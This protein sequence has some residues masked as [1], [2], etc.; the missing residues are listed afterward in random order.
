MTTPPR[1]VIG[2]PGHAHSSSLSLPPL[3]R[4]APRPPVAMD[5]DHEEARRHD[6][7]VLLQQ[8]RAAVT[9]FGLSLQKSHQTQ[10]KHH[11]IESILGLR[12]GVPDHVQGTE[13]SGE[14]TLV[15]M[16]MI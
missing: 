5:T 7:D 3:P 1:A 14:S 13:S 6:L 10:P 8:H 15:V 4:D 9:A 11:T 16:I 12:A 2:R